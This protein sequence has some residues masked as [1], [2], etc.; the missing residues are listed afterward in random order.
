MSSTQADPKTFYLQRVRTN[1]E[2]GFPT[3]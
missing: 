3:L 2:L 1:H